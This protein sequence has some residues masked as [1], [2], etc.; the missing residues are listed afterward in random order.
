MDTELYKLQHQNF[1]LILEYFNKAKLK[2]ENYCTYIQ[3]YKEHTKHYLIQIKRLYKDFL[4]SLYDKSIDSLD[5]ESNVNEEMDIDDDDEDDEDLDKNIFDLDLN[6]NKENMEKKKNSP[7]KKDIKNN[8]NL[9]LSPISKLTNCIYKQF[10]NQINGLKLFLKGIDLSVDNYKSLINKLKKETKQLESNYLD[11]KQNLIQYFSSFKKDNS[12]LLNDISSIE[13]KLVELSFFKSNEDIFKKNKNKTDDIN[14]NDI[15]NNINVEIIEIKKKEANFLQ[16]DSD[17]KKYYT[18][19][20]NKSE[21]YI[22]KI[23]NNIILLINNLKSSIEKFLSYYCNCYHFNFEDLPPNIKDIQKMNNEKEYE[24]I[25]KQ[26]LKPINEIILLKTYEFYKPINYDIK[27]LKNKTIDLNLYDKL[28]KNGYEIRKEDLELNDNDIYYIAKKMFNFSLVNK[29]NYNI[30]KENNKIMISNCFDYMF[31]S[32]EKNPKLFEKNKMVLEERK[33]KLFKLIEED[34]EYQKYS[35]QLLSNKRSKGVYELTNNVYEILVKILILI[36][37][38]T[39]N[40][41]DYNLINNVLI[42]SQTFYKLENNEKV[43]LFQKLIGHELYKKEEFWSDYISYEI[44]THI[45]KKELNEKQIGR[46]LDEKEIIRRNN[47]I[48][49]AQL[50]TMIECM[51]NF[52]LNEKQIINII[53]PMFDAYK[54][55]DDKKETILAFANMK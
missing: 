45:K 15:E 23:N 48:V 28:I 14:L 24:N 30:D 18:D 4:S 42:L 33:S 17:K 27:I 6:E 34:K 43:Y 26:N 55:E 32:K 21:E 5:K 35:L 10:K 37:D 1:L 49:F 25:I 41:M 31:C 51:K 20:N 44:V 13:N 40:E 9:D 47:D 38:K 36:T 16:K 52:G 11:I 50:M 54:M 3:K 29:G 8:F 46:I 19:F 53:S 12:E 7:I 2:A 39:L 22:K